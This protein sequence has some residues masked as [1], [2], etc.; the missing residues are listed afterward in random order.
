VGFIFRFRMA[1]RTGFLMRSCDT[2]PLNISAGR[3]RRFSLQSGHSAM[4]HDDGM[5]STGAG[6][7]C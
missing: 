6:M 2:L 5:V 1:Y 3:Y 4:I 7:F